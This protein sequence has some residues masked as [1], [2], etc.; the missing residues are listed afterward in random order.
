MDEKTQERM[1]REKLE[2]DGWVSNFWAIENRIL[3]LAPLMHRISWDG[4]QFKTEYGYDH[5][6]GGRNFYYYVI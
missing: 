3:R 6:L 1:V 4:I 5:G 2:R